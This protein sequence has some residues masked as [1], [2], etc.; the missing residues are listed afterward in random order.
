MKKIAI[1]LTLLLCSTCFGLNSV[2]A[3][4]SRSAL[5]RNPK[6]VAPN[7][8]GENSMTSLQVKEKDAFANNYQVVSQGVKQKEFSQVEK[9]FNG[10]DIEKAKNPLYQVGYSIFTAQS[11]GMNSTGKYDESYKLSIGEKVSAY[12]YGDSVDIAAISGSNL[13][14]PV[15]QTEVD[16]KGNIFISGIGVV[17][18]EN[19]SIKEV[20]S[21]I[22]RLASSKYNNLKIRLNVASGRDFSVFVYG[23]VNKPGKV[24]INNNSSI[25]DALGAA[26]GVKKTGTLRNISYTTNKKTRTVD[27]YKT[28]FSGQDDD[29]IL[30]PNDK[31]FVGGIGNVVAIKNGV[32]VTGIYETKEGESL[33]KLVSFAG[34]LLPGTQTNEVTMTSLDA[35]T[36]E[37]TAKNVSWT[38]ARN[39]KLSSGD[40][41]EFREL[42]NIAENTVT[43]Q[44]NVKHP[45]TFAYRPNM[46]LSDILKS[47]NELLEETFLTLLLDVFPE[48]ITQSKLFRYF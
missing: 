4:N 12:L 44:G 9:L 40:I 37:R 38:E 13:L 34:G 43:L 19:K 2:S 18:A 32:S 20:E 26:G 24:I 21:A 48:K 10:N 47:E 42:Y 8:Y 22:N 5:R 29:I 6:A 28:I 3:D 23:Q 11:T 16:S 46:R 31:I 27:L 41:I 33:L 30:R 17:P 39:I 14:S 36:L 1:L 45:A 25:I 7:Y 15:V 35:K